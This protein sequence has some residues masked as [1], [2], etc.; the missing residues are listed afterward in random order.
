MTRFSPYTPKVVQSPI[1]ASDIPAWDSE[2]DS[3]VRVNLGTYPLLMGIASLVAE[4]QFFTGTDEQITIAINAIL[5]Q[6]SETILHK[7]DICDDEPPEQYGASFRIRRDEG[8]GGVFEVMQGLGLPVP[9]WEFRWV[10]VPGGKRVEYRSI[11]TGGPF[12][13]GGFLED[14]T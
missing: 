7:D 11:E 10:D 9:P 2:A 14:I 8:G 4:R 3:F 5:E 6:V 13:F 1:P 12:Q